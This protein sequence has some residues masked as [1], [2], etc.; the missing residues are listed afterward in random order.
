[1]D[2]R[3]PY[4]N[5]QIEI[6][7]RILSSLQQLQKNNSR[8]SLRAYAKRIGVSAGALS[9]MLNGKRTITK[10]MALKFVEKLSLDPQEKSELIGSFQK[11]T[12]QKKNTIE[13]LKLTTD[14]FRLIADWEH[15]AILSLIKTK[16][17]QSEPQWIATRLGVSITR[18]NQAL[19]R[20]IDLKLVTRNS[21]GQLSRTKNN[22]RTSDDIIDFGLRKANDV[23]LDLAR[24][25]LYRDD[26]KDR[27]FSSITFAINPNKLAE[28]KIL[29]RQC[30][31]DLAHLLEAGSCTEVYR[32]SCQL[33][34]LSILVG[35][36]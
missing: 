36:K 23:S 3:S 18:V 29:I 33:Y 32:F 10:K 31:D 19:T 34:P 28:A 4:M 9:A 1:M 11:S 20:L 16:N 6:R 30:Q 2:Y 26:I 7:N 22:F 35:G 15:F 17:F 25:S 21:K 8:F 12:L 27:D 5:T 13:Y 14:Q 24:Q